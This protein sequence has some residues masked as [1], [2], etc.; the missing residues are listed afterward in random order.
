[1]TA[2]RPPAP[3]ATTSS[4]SPPALDAALERFEAIDPEQA[5]II[6]LR[7][8][9]GLRNEGAANALDLSPAMLKRRFALTRAWLFREFDGGH[10]CPPSSGAADATAA[11][12]ASTCRGRMP[13]PS[14]SAGRVATAKMLDYYKRMG[15]KVT[16]QMTLAPERKP[17]ARK[18]KS[19]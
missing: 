11:N 10:A 2:P 15:I 13:A 19:V 18:V 12:G 5:R 3:T 6:E 8:F 4:A 14:S 17:R 1:M 9:V 7:Y 16:P